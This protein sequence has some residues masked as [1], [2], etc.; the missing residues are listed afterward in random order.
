MS[1]SALESHQIST[2]GADGEFVFVSEGE[3]L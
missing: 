1:G 3:T 2:T